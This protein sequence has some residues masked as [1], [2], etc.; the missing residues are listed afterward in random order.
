MAPLSKMDTSLFNLIK[1]S[2]NKNAVH[3]SGLR[4]IIATQKENPR[5][6]LPLDKY[7]REPS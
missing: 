1:I 6:Y 3:E 2:R 5:R 4:F 7:R